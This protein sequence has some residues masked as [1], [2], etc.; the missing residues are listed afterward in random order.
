M[1][2]A[3]LRSGP[4]PATDESVLPTLRLIQDG[5]NQPSRSVH[6]I[7]GGAPLVVCSVRWRDNRSHVIHAGHP[8][9]KHP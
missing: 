8:G 1:V 5:G 7:Q 3:T 9:R 6:G 4:R 2:I